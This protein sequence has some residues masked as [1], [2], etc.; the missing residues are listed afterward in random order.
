MTSSESIFINY[1]YQCY[2]FVNFNATS[3]P[4][5]LAVFAP[6]MFF[7]H[8][9]FSNSMSFR[10]KN[11]LPSQMKNKLNF[12]S[13]LS[14]SLPRM[15]FF[16]VDET[17]NSKKYFSTIHFYYYLVEGRDADAYVPAIRYTFPP[18]IYIMM[19][20]NARRMHLGKWDGNFFS[21]S[22]FI[23]SLDDCWS[24]WMVS[25]EVKREGRWKLCYES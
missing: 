5:S 1:S 2:Q 22:L 15:K 16:T 4:S 13:F 24:G 11:F 19:N 20:D 7:H 6:Q 23:S 10:E 17:N 12:S 18:S 8:E 21:S 3:T 9:K 25:V 14:L